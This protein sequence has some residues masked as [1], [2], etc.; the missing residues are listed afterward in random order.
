MKKLIIGVLTIFSIS[1]GA[2]INLKEPPK[3]LSKYYPPSSNKMEF[4]NSMYSMSTAFTG[5]FTNIQ[6]NDWKNAEKW[7]TILRD[8]YLNIGKMI[9]EFDKGLKKNEIN[10]LVEA[11]KSK[12]MEKIKFNADAIGKSCM[13]CH[14]NYQISAKILYHYPSFDLINLEDPVSRST[15][16]FHDYMKKTADSMKKMKVY[17]EDGKFDKAQKEGNDF[18]KRVKALSQSCNECHNSKLSV[19]IYQ[20]KDLEEKLNLLSKAL[21]NKNKDEVYKTVGWISGNNCSKCHNTHQTVA[22][23]KEKFSK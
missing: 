23:I 18:I 11:V 22:E 4:L 10:A 5:M 7:A 19:E 6:E 20:G 9:P 8:N 2:D 1:Y 16:E 14:Q 12:D 13:Q 3:S 15:I 17:I 21:Q